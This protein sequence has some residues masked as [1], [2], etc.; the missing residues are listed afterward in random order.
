MALAY[1]GR[2]DIADAVWALMRLHPAEATSG[3]DVEGLLGRYLSTAGQPDPDLVIRTSGERRLSG[4]M[5]WQAAQAELYFT[6][7]AWPDFNQQAC[8]RRRHGRPGLR[9]QRPYGHRA[10]TR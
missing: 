6:D 2:S 10:S 9:L 5:T 7:T 4:F 3:A 1:S 8:V